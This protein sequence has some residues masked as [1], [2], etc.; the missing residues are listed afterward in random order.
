MNK[1]LL[2]LLFTMLY[3]TVHSQTYYFSNSGD[4]LYTEE[5]AQNSSTPWKTLDKLNSLS[6][7]PGTTILLKKAIYGED[8]SR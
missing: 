1:L 5:Q 7:R 3:S 2:I 8:K 4:D 6:L